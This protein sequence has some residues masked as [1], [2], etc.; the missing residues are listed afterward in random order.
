[1]LYANLEELSL[2][3][4][5]PSIRAYDVRGHNDDSV[6][7]IGRQSLTSRPSARKATKKKKKYRRQVDHDLGLFENKTELMANASKRA[8]MESTVAST[9]RTLER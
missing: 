2:S 3:R 6:C 7:G 5:P 9:D 1:M 4:I 8:G